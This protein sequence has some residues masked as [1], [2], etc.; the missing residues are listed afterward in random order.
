MSLNLFLIGA[1]I[2]AFL[3]SFVN[4]VAERSVSGRSWWG[5]ERSSC[6]K[7]GKILSTIELIPLISFII[8]RGRCRGCGKFIGM[9]YFVTEIIG[10]AMSGLLLAKWNFSYAF[11]VSLTATFLLFISALT[12]YEEGYIYDIFSLGML[13]PAFL[14]RL[15]GGIPSL[16]NGVYGA[17]LGFGIFALIILISRGGMGWGDAFLMSGI[18]GFV[19]WELVIVAFYIGLMAGGLGVVYLMCRGKVKWGKKQTMP[20]GPYLAIGGYIALLYGLDILAYLNTKFGLQ[21]HTG[22]PW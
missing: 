15:S 4:V 12:D 18:G 10:A 22:F 11:A 21:L 8:Q 5:K 16:L 19:G 14:F 1:V 9:R 2:G 13:V 3:A 20:L 17:V 6:K 7:C